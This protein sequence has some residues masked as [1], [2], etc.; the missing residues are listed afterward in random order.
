MADG[1]SMIP[2]DRN[3]LAT[4]LKQA[5]RPI[6]SGMAFLTMSKTGNWSVG[7]E[8]T[9]VK[10]GALLAI[11]PA[12]FI[13]G[14]VAWQDTSNGQ[15]AA[16]L[17]EVVVPVSK[18]IP[19]PGAVPPGA[20]GWE[21]QLGLTL[22]AL[23]DGTEMQYLST[24]VGG[25]RAVVVIRDLVIEKL[26]NGGAEFVPVVKLEHSTYRHKAYGDIATPSFTVVKWVS[27]ASLEQKAK[28][29]KAL[30]KAKAPAK[31]RK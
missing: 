18:A 28:E 26:T 9:P 12:G 7:A 13:H 23:D 14:K 15:A 31:K 1:T 5:P 8:R 19:D 24:S 21:D 6:S 20:R 27:M 3:K 17:G 22:K 11:N 25:K 10:A 30:P 2:F 4:E 29:P 16:K